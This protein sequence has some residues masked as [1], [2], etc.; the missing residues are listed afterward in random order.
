MD[1][2]E[3]TSEHFAREVLGI[4]GLAHAIQK[5]AI[6]GIDVEV[7]QL[8]ERPAIAALRAR[9][10]IRDRSGDLKLERGDFGD[11]WPQAVVTSLPHVRIGTISAPDPVR[12]WPMGTKIVPGVGSRLL[13]ESL[14]LRKSAQAYRSAVRFVG[15]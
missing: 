8:G 15:H 13:S 10:H 9:D 7:V 4:G 5:V 3:G 1:V 14:F 6:H 2:R 11:A 12:Q